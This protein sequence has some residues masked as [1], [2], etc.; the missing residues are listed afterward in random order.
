MLVLVNFIVEKATQKLVLSWLSRIYGCHKG[1][2]TIIV[3]I[4]VS[5]HSLQN[6]CERV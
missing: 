1:E 6:G 3:C 2:K 4:V 5:Y